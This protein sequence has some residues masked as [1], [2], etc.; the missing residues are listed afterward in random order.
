M[1]KL[2][3][4]KNTPKAQELIFKEITEIEGNTNIENN[5]DILISKSS[6][7]IKVAEIRTIIKETSSKPTLLKNRYI[8]IFNFNNANKSA[9]N[10]FLKTLEEGSSSVYLHAPNISNI[11]DTVLSRVKLVTVNEKVTENT[12]IKNDL[13][14]V[15]NEN[16]L[17][18]ITKIAKDYDKQEILDNLEIVLNEAITKKDIDTQIV[19]DFYSLKFQ[20]FETNLNF[21]LQL[22][23]VLV[24]LI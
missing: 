3:I 16:N 4:C 9:Q 15:I 11:L 24:K 19:K 12:K 5:P 17:V 7:E 14:E 8:V 10:A 23:N 1:S 6:D 21:E 22:T 2:F 13:L 20:N 18:L